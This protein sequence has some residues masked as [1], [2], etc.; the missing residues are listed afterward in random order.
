[1]SNESRPEEHE[2]LMIVYFDLLM[3]DGTSLLALSHGER[4][5]QLK[6]LVSIKEGRSHVVEQEVVDFTGPDAAMQLRNIFANCIVSRGEGLVLKPDDPYFDMDKPHSRPYSSCCIKMKKE[7]IGSFGDVGDLAVVGA[8]FEAASSKMLR[9]PVKFTHFFLACLKNKGRCVE[10]DDACFVVVCVVELNKACHQ[11]LTY[12][13]PVTYPYTSDTASNIRLKSGISHGRKPTH[14]FSPPL[15]FDVRCF[16]FDKAG[17]TGFWSPR[18]PQVTKVHFDRSWQDVLEFDELQEI[19]REATGQ[20]SAID[21]EDGQETR[22]WIAALEAADPCTPVLSHRLDDR[23]Q[24]TKTPEIA[25]STPGTILGYSKIVS[26]P[27]AAF[28]RGLFSSSTREQVFNGPGS[29]MTSA[30]GN[31]AIKRQADSPD[32]LPKNKNGNTRSLVFSSPGPSVIPLGEADANGN[33]P[34]S[35]ISTQPG[36]STLH[37]PKPTN[38][39]RAIAAT[40]PSVSSSVFPRSVLP[41]SAAAET[42]RA[43]QTAVPKC[44]AEEGCT[45]C[46]NKCRISNRI[47]IL[48]P[49]LSFNTLILDHLRQHHAG[50][51]IGELDVPK[52]IKMLSTFLKTETVTS[53][54]P[55]QAPPTQRRGGAGA[56]KPAS[57]KGKLCLV[58]GKQLEETKRLLGAIERLDLRMAKYPAKRDWIPCY[59]WRVLEMEVEREDDGR[60]KEWRGSGCVRDPWRKKFVGLV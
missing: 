8:L 31:T 23:S 24:L 4:F 20:R 45:F 46:K 52:C 12:S 57:S 2:H 30:D 51:V 54:G 27:A 6:S 48:A 40:A 38:R 37:I 41:V 42:G 49:S 56:S 60:S 28:P 55:T 36:A 32:M 26:K 34:A 44:A 22:D 39:E 14:V 16:S 53:L 59:D 17:N 35:G 1:M 25:I 29:S 3:R 11:A 9:V 47:V 33:K 43:E 50:K 19:A 10:L 21:I 7:Y 5:G 15:V 13:T 18:F 58:D